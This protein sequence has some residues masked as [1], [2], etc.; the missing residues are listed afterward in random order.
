MAL[1]F[2]G[3]GPCAADVVGRLKQPAEGLPPMRATFFIPPD[4]LPERSLAARLEA[5]G[6]ELALGVPRVPPEWRASPEALRSGL[7]A[8][9]ADLADG[10]AERGWGGA[11]PRHWRPGGAPDP[12]TLGR[13]ADAERPVVLWSVYGEGTAELA[14]GVL[15]RLA[16]GEVIALPTSAPEC[17]AVGLVTEVAKGLAS[18]RLVAVP[19]GE[20]LAAELGRHHPAQ[21]VRYLGPGLPPHCA[22]ALGR[23]GEVDVD[24]R[25]PR[26]GLVHDATA[27]AVRVLPVGGVEDSTAALLAGEALALWAQRARWR[28]M[29]GCLRRISHH[30]VLSPIAAAD[31]SGRIQAAQWWAAGEEGLAERDAR[32]VGSPGDPAVLPATPDLVRLEARQRLPWTLRGLV[33]DALERLSLETPMLV[34]A[35]AVPAVVI[36]RPLEPGAPPADV[37][38]A[39]GAFT[40]VVEISLAEYLFLALSSPVDLPQLLRVARA[41]DGFLRPGPFL[42]L[43]QGGLPDGR[44][45]GPDGRGFSEAPALLVQ[46][47]LDTGRRLQPGDVVT[48][49][50]SSLLGPPAVPPG[51]AK[52]SRRARLRHGLA[53]SILVGSSRPGYLRPGAVVRVEGDLLGVQEV[54]VAVPA[55]VAV[56]SPD[57][58]PLKPVGPTEERP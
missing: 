23:P 46:R 19:V 49:L 20:L 32:A 8:Q 27:K 56:P 18:R 47:V 55:G 25:K 45:I 41:G 44:R 40:Q 54:R 13:T 33:A 21:A 29:P 39:L 48:A 35:R 31:R 11:L 51:D 15:P 3:L 26:W 7:A 6:H 17:P 22:D 5:E 36:S 34:E 57:A 52:L 38:A 28:T 50:P 30:Q 12:F 53:R 43:R 2:D 14:D 42:V 16:G 37:D 1:T 10:L 24:S 4:D 9:A 58:V